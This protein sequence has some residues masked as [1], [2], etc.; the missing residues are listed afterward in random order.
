MINK[1]L[2][3]ILGISMLLLT[4]C[5]FED[6][7]TPNGEIPVSFVKWVGPLEG[8][9]PATRYGDWFQKIQNQFYFEMRGNKPILR[10]EFDVIREGCHS[11]IGA[12][13]KFSAIVDEKTQI[14][15]RV[16]ATFALNKGNCTSLLGKTV[17]IEYM[18]SIFGK[19]TLTVKILKKI[20]KDPR[21]HV[22]TPHYLTWSL[23]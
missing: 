7:H 5:T 11:S 4:S 8:T 23:L 3:M 16:T 12:L 21:S 2:V 13:Q 20:T 18:K 6:V 15:S 10:S 22:K 1:S 17:D 9:Y 14:P 19:E